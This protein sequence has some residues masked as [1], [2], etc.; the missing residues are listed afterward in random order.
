MVGTLRF[1]SPATLE[2]VIANSVKQSIAVRVSK[3][4]I[5]SSLRSQ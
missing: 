2:T 3:D 5:A 1:A 4:W